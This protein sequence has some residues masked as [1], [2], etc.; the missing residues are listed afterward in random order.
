MLRLDNLV[1]DFPGRHG[2]FT[3]IDGVSLS[4]AEGEIHGLVGESGAGKSTL[5]QLLQQQLYSII[6]TC[7]CVIE[8]LRVIPSLTLYISEWATPNT[9]NKYP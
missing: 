2:T 1:V 9:L 4:I 6:Y 8:H 3:A 7:Q 5:I